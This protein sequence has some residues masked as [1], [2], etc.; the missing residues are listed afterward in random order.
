[1]NNIKDYREN[2]LKQYVVATSLLF[3]LLHGFIDFS[4]PQN[5]D[6][7]KGIVSFIG[8]SIL[9]S[10][11]Y[12]FTLVIDG[13]MDDK[14]KNV[15]VNLWFMKLPGEYIF[16]EIKAKNKDIRF[17]TEEAYKDFQLYIVIYL[18]MLEKK[19]FMK[20]ANGIKYIVSIEKIR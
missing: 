4:N 7:I 10:V 12:I 16:T 8:T 1:M 15:I 6:Y 13:V 5:I 2:E 19:E 17:T 14:L 11:I 9:T 3:L 18:Q 20:I